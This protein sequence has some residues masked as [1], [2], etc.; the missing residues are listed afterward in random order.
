MGKPRQPR[1]T[2]RVARF[3]F[4]DA[5]RLLI[6]YLRKKVYDPD[7]LHSEYGDLIPTVDMFSIDPDTF[8]R[9]KTPNQKEVWYFFSPI[10]RPPGSGPI[11][12][13][14]PVGDGFWM[15]SAPQE[16]IVDEQGHKIGERRS[17]RYRNWTMHEYRLIDSQHAETSTAKKTIEDNAPHNYV[18]CKIFEEEAAKQEDDE[19]EGGGIQQ[20]ASAATPSHAGQSISSPDITSDDLLDWKDPAEDYDEQI[21]TEPSA[22]GSPESVEPSFST[23]TTGA[24]RPRESCVPYTPDRAVPAGECGGATELPVIKEHHLWTDLRLEPL[25]WLGQPPTKSKTNTNPRLHTR[26][27]PECTISV[28]NPSSPHDLVEMGS[29]KGTSFAGSSTSSTAEQKD[30]T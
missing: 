13:D 3:D 7:G 24:W 23:N 16:D 5:D 18:L 17:R 20:E 25:P 11:P 28:P 29:A 10:D 26:D 2:K 6:Y 1:K 30:D 12:S 14:R 8:I 22:M 4:D 21:E 27:D 15:M 19:A 9:V